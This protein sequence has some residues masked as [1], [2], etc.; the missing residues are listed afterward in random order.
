MTKSRILALSG[1]ALVVIPLAAGRITL[2]LTDSLPRGLWVEVGGRRAIEPG[3]VVKACLPATAQDRRYIGPG[4]CPNGLMPVLKPVV[5]TAG[6]RVTTSAG[7]ISVNGRM[8]PGSTPLARD[9]AG[10]ALHHYPFGTYPVAA[11]EA[12]LISN[13]NRLSYDSRY[14]GPVKTRSIDSRERPLLTVR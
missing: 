3:D 9:E 14:F 10:R 13:Y 1:V 5:A 12:W 7:G 6:D 4:F 2:N 8:V 11:G